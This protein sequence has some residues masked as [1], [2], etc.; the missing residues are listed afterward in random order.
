MLGCDERNDRA[1]KSVDGEPLSHGF[2][3]VFCYHFFERKKKEKR[4]KSHEAGNPMRGGSRIENAV[5]APAS[6]VVSLVRWH[7]DQGLP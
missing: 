5:P 6:A 1:E 3:K 2:L 7:E 4:T